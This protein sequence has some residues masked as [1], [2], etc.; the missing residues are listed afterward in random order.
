MRTR[1]AVLA[2]VG[3]SACALRARTSA[4]PCDSA[5]TTL[6]ARQCLDD[7][8]T[9]LDQALG[10]ALDSARRR[11]APS[12]ILDSAQVAWTAYRRAQCTAEGA[13]FDGGTEAPVAALYCW[14]TLTRDRLRQVQAMY[15]TN[16]R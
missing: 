2:A 15:R 16:A 9:H 8:V 3:I 14:R 5:Q 12:A 10:A 11:G 6:A 1:I 13:E 4:D 7:E